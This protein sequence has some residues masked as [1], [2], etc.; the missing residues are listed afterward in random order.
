MQSPKQQPPIAAKKP[1]TLTAH[2]H[3]R[4]DNYY[5]LKEKDDAAVMAHIEAENTYTQ[6]MTE[7]TKAFQAQ[8]HQEIASQIHSAEPSV[9]YFLN[10]YYYYHRYQEGSHYP[11][12]C[13]KKSLDTSSEEE[14]ILDVNELAEGKGYCEVT[15]LTI[16]D[17]HRFL[18]FQVDYSGIQLYTLCFKDLH[19]N[20]VL[21]NQIPH[22]A[23]TAIWA[24]DNQTI[25][26]VTRDLK[27]MRPRKVWR[28]NIRRTNEP[29]EEIFNETDTAFELYLS[30]TKSRN[31]MLV[32]SVSTYSTEVRFLETDHP[33]GHL[34][35]FHR[36]EEGLEYHVEHCEDKFYILTNW[37]APNY[38]VM[39]RYLRDA[40]KEDWQEV[41][42]TQADRRLEG[43][44]IFKN[45][46]LLQE[47]HQG[48][49]QFRVMKWSDQSTYYLDF[50]EKDYSVHLGRNYEYDTSCFRY[51]FTS[52][53]TPTTVYD[54][55]METRISKA[56]KR[57]QVT[58]KTDDLVDYQVERVYATSQDG[59]QIPISLVF[60]KKARAQLSNKP[61][62]LYSYGAYGYSVPASFQ[63][64]RL[65][66]LDRGFTYA[67]AYPRGGDTL[68]DD[69]YEEGKLLQKKNTFEDFIACAEYL[70]Q[71]NYT[72]PDQLFIYGE[73][74]G[75]LLVASVMNQ[76][77][78][79]FKG[80]IASVPFV[81]VVTTMLDEEIP[82]TTQEFQEWGDPK[83][84]TYFDYQLSY[85]P[86]DQIKAQ[87]YPHLLVTT[88]LEDTK[89]PYWEA[90]KWVAKLR[91]M[92]TDDH[93]LLL[94]V[95][96]DAGHHGK[97]GLHDEIKET[98]F[99]YAFLLELAGL[100]A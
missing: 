7:S 53:A 4:V 74:A 61:L 91:D 6:Q 5:W 16:S 25:F 33:L 77:P 21:R 75:G 96:T 40:P 32:N 78:E 62:L 92:K 23:G 37:Q 38:R 54:F 8:L 10:G 88:G 83:D 68:G 22:T 82:F 27:T 24:G 81:D 66:L 73:S 55:D 2:G 99:K 50:D 29:P 19:R 36:R 90:V 3:D 44:E 39:S 79:L 95:D 94:K 48:L 47:R 15:G 86:Y 30:R 64:T 51:I 97:S 42:P 46:M 52:L 63:A 1:Q 57:K 45:F 14:V 80:A 87:D 28:Y 35:L 13:R 12:H 65:S 31:Y 84:K 34:K 71:E 11:I 49:V 18:A 56:L 60:N 69:W 93:Q 43:V 9:P 41:I 72:T 20:K 26:F 58:N 17:D 67:I 76:R 85:S 100:Q 98:A 89:V 70:I 59:K